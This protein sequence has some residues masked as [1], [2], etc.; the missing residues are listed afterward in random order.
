MTLWK[1]SGIPE[2]KIATAL[3]SGIKADNV[4]SAIKRVRETKSLP[5]HKQLEHVFHQF[6][7]INS[8]RNLI[9]HFGATFL[10]G[11]GPTVSNFRAAHIEERIQGFVASPSAL[12]DMTEDLKTIT[13][14]LLEIAQNYDNP[15]GDGVVLDAWLYKYK[16][17]TNNRQKNPDKTPKRQRPQKPSRG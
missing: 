2:I 7:V 9:V 15:Y 13:N 11:I 5:E 4:L 3:L 14:R 8:A 12:V 10:E 17:L 16:L 6:G 1:V